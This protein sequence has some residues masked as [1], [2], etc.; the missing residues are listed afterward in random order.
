M[1]KSDFFKNYKNFVLCAIRLNEKSRREGIL[2]LEDEVEDLDDENFKMG[3]R[4]L[5]D[6]IAYEIVDEIYS[7]LISFEKD[8]LTARLMTVQKRALFGFYRGE[9]NYVLYKVLKSY[10][11]LSPDENKEMDCLSL[12]DDPVVSGNSNDS[13]D[14]DLDDGGM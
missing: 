4:L 12:R 6:G 2:S 9:N 11:N 13:D 3:L 8:E 5:I 10:A 7:N 14:L 1:N